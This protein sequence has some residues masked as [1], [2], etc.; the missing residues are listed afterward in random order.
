ML[1]KN[2]YVIQPVT[3]VDSDLSSYDIFEWPEERKA[4][5]SRLDEGVVIDVVNSPKEVIVRVVIKLNLMEP[6]EKG[7]YE[8]SAMEYRNLFL[9]KVTFKLSIFLNKVCRDTYILGVYNGIR[10]W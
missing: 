5:D 3:R 6:V 10:S 9:I 4:C 1:V 8:K 2:F 7:N